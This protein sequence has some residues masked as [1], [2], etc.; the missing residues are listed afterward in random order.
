MEY[1]MEAMTK[2]EGCAI[3]KEIM[4]A[5]DTNRALWIEKF[6]TDEGFGD[7]FTKQTGGNNHA[8]PNT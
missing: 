3:L 2:E 8:K 1:G 5:W 7:W 4:D 6:G